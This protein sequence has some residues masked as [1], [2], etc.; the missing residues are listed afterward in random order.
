MTH[1]DLHPRRAESEIPAKACGCVKINGRS[2]NGGPFVGY[3]RECHSR[4]MPI[5][6]CHEKI[7]IALRRSFTVDC[8]PEHHQALDMVFPTEVSQGRFHRGQNLLGGPRIGR[9]GQHGV[10]EIEMPY[11]GEEY[12]Q[13]LRCEELNGRNWSYEVHTARWSGILT[14][15][16]IVKFKSLRIDVRARG[17]TRAI[18]IRANIESTT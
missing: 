17:V 5:L 9:R 8:G 15:Y 14:C 2:K 3:P 11:P 10:D 12:R 6:E 18:A 13:S 7:N 16:G 1:R 4:C